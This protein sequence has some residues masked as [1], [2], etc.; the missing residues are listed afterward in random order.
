M[1]ASIWC[2]WCLGHLSTLDLIAF[3]K[4]AKLALNTE[5]DSLI[6]VKENL[7]PDEP[8]DGVQGSVVFDEDDSSLTRCVAS[9]FLPVFFLPSRSL[10]SLSAFVLLEPRVLRRSDLAWKY[11]FKQ[12]GLTLIREEVQVRSR[13]FFSFPRIIPFH[14][15]LLTLTPLSLASPLASSASPKSSSPSSCAS[16]SSPVLPSSHSFLYD[17]RLTLCSL[18]GLQVRSPL[19]SFLF[20]TLGIRSE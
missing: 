18:H 19:D 8:K 17:P 15:F 11:A 9:P 4:K 16:S 5:P 20:C 12:A 3:F 2:Q 6:V 14:P 7:C 1:S 13:L 10:G